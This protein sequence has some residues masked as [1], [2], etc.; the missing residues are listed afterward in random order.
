MKKTICELFAWVWW[1]RVWFEILNKWWKTVWANQR[2]PNQKWQYAFNCY[3]NHF[4]KK[5]IHVNE[6]IWTIDKKIIPSHNLLVWWFPCQDYSV[7]STWAKWIQG[8]KWVLRRQIRE[9][10][11]AKKP[12]FVLLENVDRLLKSPRTQKWRDFGVILQTFKEEWYTVEW[13]V[14]NAAEYWFV[15]KRKRTFIFAS[16]NETNYARNLQNMTFEKIIHKDWFFVKEFPIIKSTVW[17]EYDFNF[18][19][20]LSVSDNFELKFLNTWIMRNW[21]IYTEETVPNYK[22]EYALLKDVLEKK[23][24]DKYNIKVN[25]QKW[26]DLKWSKAIPKKV[27]DYEYIYREWAMAF[28][29]SLEKPARTMLTSEWTL[30]RSS[31]IIK[32]W[33]KYR[34]LTPIETERI[35]GFPDNWTDTWMPERYRYF[36]MG[37]ALVVGL[38]EKMWHRLNTIFRKEGK[39]QSKKKQYKPKNKAFLNIRLLSVWSLYAVLWYWKQAQKE[40]KHERYL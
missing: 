10:L 21:K 15:Q 27:W 8:K 6:D 24:D 29:D 26:K 2:E 20:L 1:F 35:N 25:L 23:V 38:I 40:L 19:N 5:K 30:N 13:R 9:I 31:H 39:I 17:K 32:N 14:I 28:P 36:C 7:A 37:N 16:R 3:I 34:I 22:W 18:K 4:W 11:I 12:S 33:K